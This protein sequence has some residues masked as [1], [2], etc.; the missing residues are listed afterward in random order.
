MAENE[1]VEVPEEEQ[2]D[3]DPLGPTDAN[4]L[5][6]GDDLEMIEAAW[7]DPGEIVEGDLG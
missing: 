5:E 2:L 3:A 1:F 7:K 4:A 6:G